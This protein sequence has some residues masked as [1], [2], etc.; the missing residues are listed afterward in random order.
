MRDG[1]WLLDP[2]GLHTRCCTS[3]FSCGSGPSP[4]PAGT[5]LPGSLCTP[6]SAPAAGAPAGLSSWAEAFS[7][8]CVQAPSFHEVGPGGASLCG[9][10]PAG[11]VL[12]GCVAWTC[13]GAEL[14]VRDLGLPTTVLDTS[15]GVL[16]LH[17]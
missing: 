10:R 5:L 2:P 4:Q 17:R 15:Q 6:A 11:G 1:R 7:L 14:P 9:C 16:G 3:N 13:P 12:G 8:A